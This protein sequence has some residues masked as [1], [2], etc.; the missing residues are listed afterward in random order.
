MKNLNCIK[1]ILKSIVFISILLLASRCNEDASETAEDASEDPNSSSHVS[2]AAYDEL[3]GNFF[4]ALAAGDNMVVA[5]TVASNRFGGKAYVYDATGNNWHVANDSLHDYGITAISV[6]NDTIL[7]GTINGA[8]GAGVYKL[9]NGNYWEAANTGMPIYNTPH[10]VTTEINGVT[11]FVVMER[12]DPYKNALSTGGPGKLFVGTGVGVFVSADNGGSWKGAN[13]GLP[14]NGVS[15]L[16][17]NGNRIFAGVWANSFGGGV[18]TSDD[19]GESWHEANN[20]IGRTEIYALAVCDNNIFASTTSAN[21]QGV[22]ISTDNGNNWQFAN[23]GL[24]HN[25]VYS[26]AVSGNVI[27]AGAQGGGVYFSEDNGLSW[28]AANQNLGSMNVNALLVFNGNLIA[29]TSD[30]L[31]FRPIN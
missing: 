18:Y 22:Y 6:V 23:E 12:D 21:G 2:W 27:Y 5:G 25:P 20:G 31:F 8:R 11:S 17:V 1:P 28:H 26:F 3:N 24:P 19:M 9:T 30:G 7:L 16:L 14:A 29:A 13:N 10:E 4:N 15:A